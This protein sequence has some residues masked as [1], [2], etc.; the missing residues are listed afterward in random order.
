MAAI[1]SGISIILD[2]LAGDI[3]QEQEEILDLA[4]RNVDRLA[5]LIN[6]VL[7]F[8]KLQAG[9]MT[10]SIEESN[11]NAI[12]NDSCKSMRILVESKGLEFK[13]ELDNSLDSVKCDRDKISQVVTNL[14]NNAVKFT[15][16]G[17]ILV[18]TKADSKGVTVTVFDT[19]IGIKQEDLMKVFYSFEQVTRK[20]GGSEGTGLGLA[21]CKEI[22]E[23]HFG[24]IWVKSEFG[25]G[26]EFYFFIPR[27]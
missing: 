2:G 5:R 9:K 4:R 21:I 19:G 14:I 18:R 11:I 1:K 13:I 8:Q 23:R 6:E 24:R 20:G 10:F 26:S 12:V 17:H 22:I 15:Q 16:K 7:D 27:T 3:N 25:K